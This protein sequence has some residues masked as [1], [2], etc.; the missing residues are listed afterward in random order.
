[1]FI[2]SAGVLSDRFAIACDR[3]TD[4]VLS[5][6]QLVDCNTANDGCNGGWPYLAWLYMTQ[7]G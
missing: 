7:V 4:E 5:A 2:C 3:E 6:Q 1:M